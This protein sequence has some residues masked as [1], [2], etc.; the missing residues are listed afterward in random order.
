MFKDQKYGFNRGM[1]FNIGFQIANKTGR[2]MCY[3]FHDV[4]NLPA[5]DLILYTCSDYPRHQ[6]VSIEKFGYE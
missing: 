4:D 2:Y 6:S 5:N 1:L 3:V